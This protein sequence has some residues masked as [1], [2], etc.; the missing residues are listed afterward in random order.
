MVSLGGP[1]SDHFYICLAVLKKYKGNTLATTC[2]I[3]GVLG[4]YFYIILADLL[5]LFA[6]VG[7]HFCAIFEILVSSRGPC[8]VPFSQIFQILQEA[9]VLKLRLE[10]WSR[11]GWTQRA[12]LP[13]CAETAEWWENLLT[14]AP[15]VGVRRIYGLRPLP[16]APDQ[17][18]LLEDFWFSAFFGNSYVFFVW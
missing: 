6:Y 4:R 12:G 13:E 7:S 2:L 5:R 17:R 9:N 3:S 18:S 8:R 15:P 10:K 14:L 16:L 1:F 11:S